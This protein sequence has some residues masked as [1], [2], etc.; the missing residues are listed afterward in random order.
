MD[1]SLADIRGRLDPVERPQSRAP[2]Q[3][4]AARRHAYAS[5]RYHLAVL[6]GARGYPNYRPHRGI[7]VATEAG[8]HLRRLLTMP[9]QALDG[10]LR[11]AALRRGA[12]PY[13][14]V[15]LQ[16]CHDSAFRRHGPFP[17]MED[18]ARQLMEPFASAAP[19][20]HHLVFKAHPFEDGRERIRGTLRR[21][22]GETGLDDRVQFVAAAKLGRLLDHAHT[23]I[24]VNS[25]AAQQALWRGVPTKA[26][27]HAVYGKAGLVSAQSL[28]AFLADPAPVDM[29]AYMDYRRFLL[30]TSQIKGSFYTGAG[31]RMILR[32]I[33]D[34][35]LAPAGPYARAET[36]VDQVIPFAR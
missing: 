9:V 31:R 12:V 24:T 32:R 8:L 36:Q 20:H 30:E 5:A 28:A 13:H 23:A 6:M 2:D 10:R 16:L 7:S 34:M 26:L 18:F 14:L 3:W 1:M 11:T 19:A 22:A 27:G 15:L 25:T 35:M 33:V 4:G 17:T 21:L 29:A